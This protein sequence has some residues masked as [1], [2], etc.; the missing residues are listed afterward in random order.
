MELNF[1]LAKHGCKV[2]RGIEFE[3]KVKHMS[4]LPLKLR[5]FVAKDK[6]EKIFLPF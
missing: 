1:S 6:K 3:D 5:K 2:W 4:G